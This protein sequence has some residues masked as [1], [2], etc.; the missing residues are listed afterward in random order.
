M[1]PARLLFPSNRTGQPAEAF[2]AVLDP[3]CR[4]V[5]RLDLQ[6]GRV[7]RGWR[8][9][10]YPAHRRGY[11]PHP[12]FRARTTDDGLAFPRFL[13]VRKRSSCA[14]RDRRVAGQ[15]IRN[16][17]AR[18][19]YLQERALV[20]FEDV[21]IAPDAYNSQ[22]SQAC[23]TRSGRRSRGQHLSGNQSR[24]GPRSWQ[25][26][27]TSNWVL[28]ALP[29]GHRPAAGRSCNRRRERRRAFRDAAAGSAWHPGTRTALW[30]CVAYR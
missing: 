25:A 15:Q 9:A 3:V 10:P 4:A 2:F 1:Q 26:K 11:L 12:A 18:L 23:G 22:S 13:F 24:Y 28:I 20:R 6:L 16:P 21:P 19:D 30:R 27:G 8:I 7:P 29:P 17:A 14:K 5:A